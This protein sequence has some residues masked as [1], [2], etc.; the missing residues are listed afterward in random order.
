MAKKKN[1]FDNTELLKYADELDRVAGTMGLIQATEAAMKAAKTEINNDVTNDMQPGNLPAK[2]RYST[3]K[4][5]ESLDRDMTVK[6]DGNIATLPLGFD[7]EKSGIT[8][9]LLMNGTPK[10][11]PVN[12]L[13]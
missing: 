5:L 6:W 7:M 4:T 3:G 12:G 1:W 11:Q 9:I 8:S 2:G 10:M 13:K